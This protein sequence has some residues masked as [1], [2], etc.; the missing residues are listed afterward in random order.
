VGNDR[1]AY[2]LAD[3][4]RPNVLELPRQNPPAAEVPPTSKQIATS[5][6]HK[7]TLQHGP[8]GRVL[9][10]RTGP[11]I[12]AATLSADGKRAVFCLTGEKLEKNGRMVVYDLAT[13]TLV[14]SAETK[15]AYQQSADLSSDGRLLLTRDSQ[16]TATLWALPQ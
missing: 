1:A 11:W 5:L 16:N 15:G 8:D 9:D 10:T 12:M 4:K 13:A 2:F 14:F 3:D 7:Y 6:V